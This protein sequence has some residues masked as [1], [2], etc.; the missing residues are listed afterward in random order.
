MTVVHACFALQTQT[1]G[2]NDDVIAAAE[3]LAGVHRR[4][5]GGAEGGTPVARR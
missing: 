3:V 4:V 2:L 5:C 1:V